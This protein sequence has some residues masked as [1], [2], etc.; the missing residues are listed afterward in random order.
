[1]NQSQNIDSTPE[2]LALS[3]ILAF[4]WVNEN[5]AISGQPSLDELILI[6]KAGYE[7]VINLALTDATHQL[8]GEDC[9]VLKLGMDYIGLPLLFDRPSLTQALRILDLLKSLQH[10]KVWLH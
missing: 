1:M 10:Q 4:Q 9:L 5:L 6:A 3:Q 8:G 2:Y 7:V